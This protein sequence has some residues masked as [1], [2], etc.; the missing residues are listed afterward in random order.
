MRA[1]PPP[2]LP[3]VLKC[4]KL[5]V[6]LSAVMQRAVQH[7]THTH[8]RFCFVFKLSSG[9]SQQFQIDL[10]ALF[11]FLFV[12]DSGFV[13]WWWWT[14]A[15]NEKLW[16]LWIPSHSTR[17]SIFSARSPYASL[18][19]PHPHSSSSFLGPSLAV[20]PKTCPTLDR[21]LIVRG[22]ERH[23]HCLLVWLTC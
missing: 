10:N 7:S 13:W 16:A 1:P 22:L 9:K 11:V 2:H 14:A 20:N 6:G 12:F 18:I 8:I 19:R 3:R 17:L 15:G 21:H 23:A 4:T 5:R